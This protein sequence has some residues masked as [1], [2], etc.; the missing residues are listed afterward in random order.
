MSNI[1]PSKDI[2]TKNHVFMKYGIQTSSWEIFGLKRLVSQIW[3]NFGKFKVTNIIQKFS[4]PK[5][6][7]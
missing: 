4:G 5:S 2:F 3:E 6:E 7:E 1:V